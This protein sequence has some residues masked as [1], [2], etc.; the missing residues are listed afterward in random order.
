MKSKFLSTI[1]IFLIGAL[2]FGAD[3]NGALSFNSSLARAAANLNGRILL[4]VQ[5]Q[6]QAWYVNPVNSQ[7]YYLGRPADA[8]AVMRSLGLGVTDADLSSFKVMA[9]RRLAGRILLQVQ[10]QGQAYYV[11]PLNLKLYYL[12]RPT[13]AFNLMRSQGLGISNQDLALIPIAQTAIMSDASISVKAT[14]IIGHWLFKY[15]N[16]NY[17]IFQNLSP[18][19]YQAYAGMPKIYSYK[20]GDEPTNL[21]DS[22]YGLFLTLRSGDTSLDDL[23]SRLRIIAVENN[24]TSDQLL[25]FTLALVQYIPYDHAKLAADSNRNT[26]P[27]Y[28]YETL[29]LD[30]GVC[31][32]KTFLAV[33]LLRKLGYGAAILDFPDLNHSAVGIA[34][35]VADSLNG[36]GYCYGE[37]TNYF[38]LGVIPQSINSGQAQTSENGFTTLF[39]SSNL[40]TIEIYQKTIGKIYQGVPATRAQVALLA[41]S[42]NDLDARETEMTAIQADI[43]AQEKD[44]TAM[45]TQMDNYYNNGQTSQY[46]SLVASYNDLVNKYNAAIVNYQSKIAD[47]NQKVVDFNLAVNK[48]YQK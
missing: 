45:K 15:Q 21:R 13:D 12:G 30:R 35:P 19:L 44:L 32:D 25:E 37:T 6:G 34:C 3:F 31:S 28:P 42:K 11:N 29:Y 2:L 24:W 1:F 4:Q 10:A 18:A 7:R 43:T 8:F 41:A 26:D 48:F 22:F 14:S 40:G 33:S 47:Y 23:I 39:N 20:I 46:N 16:N 38:P 27:Y 9:P 17:E 36:S 5:A